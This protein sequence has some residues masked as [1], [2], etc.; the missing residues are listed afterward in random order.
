[1]KRPSSSGNAALALATASAGGKSGTFGTFRV[2]AG[3]A[4]VD[5]CFQ[6]T[7]CRGSSGSSFVA[8]VHGM[9]LAAVM[10][11][12]WEGCLG[13]SRNPSSTNQIGNCVAALAFRCRFCI[14]LHSVSGLWPSSNI[15]CKRTNGGVHK[16]AQARR[17]MTRD[18]GTDKGSQSTS[19]GRVTRAAVSRTT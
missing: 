10:G 8:G 7:R 3:P 17:E 11:N 1:M 5:R 18:S 2:S 16:G 14:W 19:A 6:V 4:F 9:G 12:G 15:P 13:G